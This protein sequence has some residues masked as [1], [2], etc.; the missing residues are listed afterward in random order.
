M[1]TLS[2]NSKM[3]P[4]FNNK[5]KKSEMCRG[6][7]EIREGYTLFDGYHYDCE[8]CLGCGNV[9]KGCIL[10]NGYHYDCEPCFV[11]GGTIKGCSLINGR[12]WRCKPLIE[13]VCLDEKD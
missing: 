11:C 2:S 7:S 12:H 8:P 6:C 9:R 4:R 3:D 13:D 1:T 10:I 5:S